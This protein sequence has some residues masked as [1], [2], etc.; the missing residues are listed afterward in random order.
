MQKWPL[1][2]NAS[3]HKSL[4]DLCP[5]YVHHEAQLRTDSDR[6][7][8]YVLVSAADNSFAELNVRTVK[9]FS[10]R[11][12][13]FSKSARKPVVILTSEDTFFMA[14]TKQACLVKKKT[15]QFTKKGKRLFQ[16]LSRSSMRTA[17]VNLPRFGKLSM[18]KA[19]PWEPNSYHSRTLSHW[20]TVCWCNRWS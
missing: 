18:T 13:I 15:R 3:S 9:S 8:T 7:A 14:Y 5:T 10:P 16:L 1:G 17:A 20:L 12:N 19:Q 6:Q 2:G 4:R 11:C